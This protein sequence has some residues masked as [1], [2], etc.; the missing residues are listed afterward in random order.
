MYMSLIK[1]LLYIEVGK[2]PRLCD[3][4]LLGSTHKGGGGL[5]KIG[6]QPPAL[7]SFIQ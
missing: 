7:N 5:Y 4:G 6:E 1:G 2:A 3:R